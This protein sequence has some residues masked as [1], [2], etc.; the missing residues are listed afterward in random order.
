MTKLLIILFLTACTSTELEQK[1]IEKD[2]LQLAE[3]LLKAIRYDHPTKE[4]SADLATLDFDYLH[5]TLGTDEKKLAFWINIYNAHIQIFLKEKPELF[6]NRGNFF[7]SPRITIAGTTLSFDDIEHGII[8]RSQSKLTLGLIPKLFV[9]KYE[10]KM[11]TKKRDGRIHFALNC[12]AKSCPPVAIYKADRINEQL[13]L[14]SKRF[15]ENSTTYEEEK[16]KAY[17]TA[18]FSWFRGDFGGL[19]GVKDYLRR[20]EIIEKE[21]NPSLSFNDYDWTLYLGNY[22]DL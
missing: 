4:L 10:R 11:R 2:P 3:N 1:G 14:S 19:D 16:N 12:G 13:D 21:D 6:E 5:K 17:V 20:Y 15:L 7:S 18:L 22:I 9:N 8:R